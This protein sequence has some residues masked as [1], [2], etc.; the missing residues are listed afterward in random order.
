MV[1]DF[2]S[3]FKLYDEEKGKLHRQGSVSIHADGDIT[4][5]EYIKDTISSIT[6]AISAVIDDTEIGGNQHE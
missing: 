1:I 3:S 6:N 2:N 5:M 4:S